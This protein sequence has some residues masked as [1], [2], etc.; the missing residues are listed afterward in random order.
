MRVEDHVEVMLCYCV[1]WCGGEVGD[2]VLH[3]RLNCELVCVALYNEQLVSSGI[4]NRNLEDLLRRD[5]FK[6]YIALSVAA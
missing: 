2:V 3:S 1:R 4:I 5:F 6:R